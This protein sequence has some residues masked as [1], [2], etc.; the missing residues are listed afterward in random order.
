MRRKKTYKEHLLETLQTPEDIAGYINAVIEENHIPTLMLALRDVAEA[1]GLG[2]VAEQAKLNRQN[3]YRML[4]EN[5][6]PTIDS[7]RRVL[8]VLGLGL[9]VAPLAEEVAEEQVAER[10]MSKA[11]GAVT[12]TSLG[13]NDEITPVADQSERIDYETLRANAESLA[14]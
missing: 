14:A 5:G 12:T 6:N 4:S 7:L 2:K 13:A 11:A 9:R 1:Q 10:V 3:V 8:Y